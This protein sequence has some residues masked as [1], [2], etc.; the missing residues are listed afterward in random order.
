MI[1]KENVCDLNLKHTKVI[2]EDNDPEQPRK[3]TTE[4]RK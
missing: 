4:W 1:F 2:P 3:S